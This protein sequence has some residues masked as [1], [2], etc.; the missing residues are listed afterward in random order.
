MLI[1]G[2]KVFHLT[3]HQNWEN[4]MCVKIKDSLGRSEYYTMKLQ[5]DT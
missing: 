1:L 2:S 3:I 4:E 5:Y